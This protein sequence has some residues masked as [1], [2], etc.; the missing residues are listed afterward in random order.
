MFH[1]DVVDA[2]LDSSLAVNSEAG[3]LGR[4]LFFAVFPLTH[5]HVTIKPYGDRALLRGR[6]KSSSGILVS[7][8]GKF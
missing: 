8:S 6:I 5:A 2:G 7:H 1:S 3:R 4:R